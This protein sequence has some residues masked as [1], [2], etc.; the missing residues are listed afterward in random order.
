LT[1]F[2][3]KLVDQDNKIRL[4]DEK[5]IAF[6]Y[7]FDYNDIQTLH[8]ILEL[9]KL[10][11]Q[12]EMFKLS[13]YKPMKYFVCNK[14]DR[15]MKEANLDIDYEDYI[16]ALCNDTSTMSLFKIINNYLGDRSLVTDHLFFTSAKYK[17]G[18]SFLF[19]KL[20]LTINPELN[21]NNEVDVE[22]NYELNETIQDFGF[23]CCKKYI[24]KKENKTKFNSELKLLR[25]KEEDEPGYDDNF[26]FTNVYQSKEE[27]KDYSLCVMF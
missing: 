9:S 25:L 6:L 14:Y 26:K 23:F 17:L 3:E 2:A 12:N 8:D 16:D 19:D 20:F 5:I 13:N 27:P 22:S 1:L 4:G 11:E 24:V 10:I 18:I 15:M 7:I 21:P